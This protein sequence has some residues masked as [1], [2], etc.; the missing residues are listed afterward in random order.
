[1]AS[2]WMMALTAAAAVTVQAQAALAQATSQPTVT[3]A[4]PTLHNIE[5]WAKFGCIFAAG[6][7]AMLLVIRRSLR[8]LANNQVETAKMIQS[9]KQ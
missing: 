5:L 4:D 8:T 2:K 9:L 3:V 6:A 1:M 7:V